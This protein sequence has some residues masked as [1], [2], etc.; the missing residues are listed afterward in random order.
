MSALLKLPAQTDFRRY[1]DFPPLTQT[2]RAADTFVLSQWA[3]LQ[4]IYAPGPRS[5]FTS[6]TVKV[7]QRCASKIK[8]K[9]ETKNLFSEFIKF[10]SAAGNC[11]CIPITSNTQHCNFKHIDETQGERDAILWSKVVILNRNKAT[12]DW[13]I[14][15]LSRAFTQKQLIC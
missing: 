15:Y 14:H 7:T 3:H 13:K 6:P 8:K 10:S 12:G 1:S 4:V 2:R 11:V 5:P 9:K